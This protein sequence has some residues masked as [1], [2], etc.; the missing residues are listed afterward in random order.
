MTAVATTPARAIASDLL[1]R[2]GHGLL[3]GDFDRFHPCFT[4][5][6]LLE[7]YDGQVEVTSVEQCRAIFEDMRRYF[8]AK[9]VSDLVRQVVS[10]E[11]V[12]DDRI[13]STHEARM[14]AGSQLVQAPY[15]VLSTIDRTPDGWKISRSLYAIAD[16]PDHVRI[17][18]PNTPPEGATQ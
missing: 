8:K 7:S 11:Y 12:A 13:H 17:L 5:P 2:T 18:T 10:A 6:T 14:I 1:E 16:A 15:P 3:T 4:I 9:S